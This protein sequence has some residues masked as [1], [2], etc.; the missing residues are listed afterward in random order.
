MSLALLLSTPVEAFTTLG[1]CLGILTALVALQGE[2]LPH[3]SRRRSRLQLASAG[4]I[5]LLVL[6][7]GFWSN[8]FF[9]GVFAYT[10][11]VAI[12]TVI[13]LA[14]EQRVHEVNLLRRLRGGKWERPASVAFGGGL[15]L[16]VGAGVAIGVLLV[17]GGGRSQPSPFLLSSP[18]RVSGTCING[19]CTVNECTTPAPCGLENHGRLHE[20]KPL[21]IVCQTG[22]EVATS[23]DGHHSRI[24]DR[25]PSGLYISDLFVEDTAV[26][27]FT[28]SLPRCSIA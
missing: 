15:V 14:A 24:W 2:A 16:M 18:Y 6:A 26:N 17:A 19:A 8:P 12:A 7:L 28:R 11:G 27:K 3:G 1:A 4:G 9:I 22:G 5:T 23:P 13:V 10:G 20:G 21:D 25:L